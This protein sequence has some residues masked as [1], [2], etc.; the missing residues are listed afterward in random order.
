MEAV[1]R[2][3][4]VE[5]YHRDKQFQK[6]EDDNRRLAEMNH[7]KYLLQQEKIAF[8]KEQVKLS[9]TLS[10]PLIRPALSIMHTQ[11]HTRT[12]TYVN[13][14]TDALALQVAPMCWRPADFAL[15]SDRK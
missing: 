3:Q 13:V 4:R 15:V 12:H 6:I 9:L 11:T 2:L 5:A 8:K 1:A 10:F 14:C 7:K